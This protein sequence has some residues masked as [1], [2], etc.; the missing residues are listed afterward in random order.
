MVIALLSLET[1]F[2]GFSLPWRFDVTTGDSFVDIE[3]AAPDGD[4]ASAGRFHLDTGSGATAVAV[5]G[6]RTDDPDQSLPP[7]VSGM[8]AGLSEVPESTISSVYASGG[9]QGMMAKGLL[10]GNSRSTPLTLATMRDIL[11]GGF[12]VG[13]PQ[14]LQGILGLYFPNIGGA[15][16]GAIPP[17]CVNGS[18]PATGPQGRTCVPAAGMV[19]N[20]P[21]VQQLVSSGVV[22]Q[23]TI[24]ISFEGTTADGDRYGN[25]TVGEAAP[26][27]AQL[28][29]LQKVYGLAYQSWYIIRVPSIR[30]GGETLPFSE[31]ELYGNKSLDIQGETHYFGGFFIDTGTCF[32]TLPQPVLNHTLA[33]IAR[34]YKEAGG[35][36]ADAK[37][38]NLLASGNTTELGAQPPYF[39]LGVHGRPCVSLNADEIRGL[40][41]VSLTVAGNDG[42]ETTELKYTPS[43]YLY[44]A[45]AGCFQLGFQP[46]E[47]GIIGS[48]NLQWR[49]LFVDQAAK[50]FALSP[51]A[52]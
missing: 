20:V 47:Q 27:E 51:I 8:T 32:L 23:P 12:P 38:A 26:T 17:Y 18:K 11:P 25:F 29:P 22:A 5:A 35:T 31:R 37:L 3:L 4:G 49:V 13:G 16:G 45:F 24:G 43:M 6:C 30:V 1:A 33:L 50:V 41:S 2:A 46:G 36:M 40:P 14:N 39:G 48:L 21:F 15:A 10:I 28:L 42:D 19:S 34:Q 52:V 7:V 44:P 9:W